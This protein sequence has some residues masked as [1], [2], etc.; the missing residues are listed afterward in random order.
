MDD[1]RSD[2]SNTLQEALGAYERDHCARFHMPGHKGTGMSGFWREELI[3]WDVTELSRTDNLHDPQ[4]VIQTAQ[5]EMAKAYGAKASFYVV[6]GST[7]AV[8]AMILSLEDS[9]KLLLSRDCHRSA[10]N[11]AAL[12]GIETA[13]LSPRFDNE[14]HLSG[15]VA[16]DTLDDALVKTKAT[17]VMITSPNAYGCC[18][19][20]SALADVTHRYGALLLVD[21]AHGSHFPF[22]DRLPPALGG[23]ADLFAHSQHKTMDALTQ[24]ASLHL[25]DCRITED[26]VC[27]ALAMTETTS[28][29]YLLMTS[30]D[31]SVYMAKR[32]NWTEQVEHAEELET[33]I[34]SLGGFV[35][36]HGAVPELG[37]ADRDRTR[38]VIDVS[39]RGLSGYEAQKY[40][41]DDGIFLEMADQRRLV[42]ITTPNDEPAWYERLL[43]ALAR[44]PD[45]AKRI[46]VRPFAPTEW[47]AC[48][49]AMQ[50]RNAVFAPS[51]QIPLAETDGRIASEAIG[52]YPPGIARVMPGERVDKR[53]ISN[54][55]SEERGGGALFGVHKGKVFV[56]K[57]EK[58]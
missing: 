26:R 32:R 20:I 56:V 10:V 44:L 4:T 48:E 40:L 5:R 38:L 21:G 57:Q 45:R 31:W 24:A 14:S 22:S 49:Q 3:N 12:R 51:E 52:V 54:L 18:A 17:A 11:G 30:L 13:Y 29:S 15:M 55:I 46:A 7:N 53:A 16:A 6:N 9:D 19:D 35:T 1:N 23:K 36:L 42:L 41:E 58:Q 47:I 37:I 33:Q 8:Q 25:G 28:P 39:G 34:E 27:R 43:A 50:L 2:H